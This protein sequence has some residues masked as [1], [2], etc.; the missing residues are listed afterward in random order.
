MSDITE[1]LDLLK[2]TIQE[3]DFL[4]GR[5]LS[6]EVNIRMF[7]YNPKDEMAVRSFTEKLDNE[8]LKCNVQIVDLYETFLSI[9]EDMDILEGIPEMEQD[10]GKE[11]LEEQ[12]T[13]II[14]AKVFSK[15]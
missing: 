3:D 11:F 7:C 10:D 1:R 4:Q 6:N 5:G 9:C 15:K 12:L 13:N 8:S 14:N 2:K